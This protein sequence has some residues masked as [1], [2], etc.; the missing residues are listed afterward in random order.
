MRFGYVAPPLNQLSPLS[1]LQFADDTILIANSAELS[2]R[3]LHD[4]GCPAKCEH[5]A[6]NSEQRVY[7]RS[8]DDLCQCQCCCCGG[9]DKVGL[10]VP[11][12]REVNYR[13]V[14]K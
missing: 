14:K 9:R 8:G 5:L 10:P 13:G 6:F 11:A 3:M 2:S 12:V 4:M 1:D 7:F